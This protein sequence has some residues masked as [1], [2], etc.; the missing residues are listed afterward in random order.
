MTDPS[1]VS[2]A[3]RPYPWPL[4]AWCMGLAGLVLAPLVR[5]GFLLSYDMVTVPRQ[6]LVP[7]ALGLGSALPRAVPLDAVVAVLTQ[8]VPGELVYRVALV[9]IL[10]GG[11]LGAAML[12]PH[13]STTVRV[14]AA[15]AYVWNAYVAERLVIGHWGLL[16]AYAVLP[17]LLRAG[18]AV[19]RGERGSLPTA[20]LLAALASVTPTG[21]VLATGVLAVVVALPGRHRWLAAWAAA[22]CVVLQLPWVVPAVLTPT[23]LTSDPRAVEAFAA[24]PDSPLGLVGSVL[25]LGG[26][27]N[28][29]VVPLS[30]SLWSA[31]I[32]TVA[33]VGLGLGGVGRLR[34]TVGWPAM[35]ALAGLAALG[36]V[37]SLA[38]TFGG[39]LGWAVGHVPGAGLLR[40]GPKF[41]AWYS[42]ALAPA[43]AL[44][45][46]RLAAAVS[47][48]SG[49]LVSAAVVAGVAAVLP[50]A[51]LPDLAWGVGGR[52]SPVQYPPDWEDVRDAL[53]REPAAGALVVLPYQPYRSFDWNDRRTVLDPLPRYAGVEYVVPDTLTVGGRRLAGEDPRAAA[54]AEALRMPEPRARLLRLG[55]GWVAVEHGTPGT[56]STGLLRELDPVIRG[57]DLELYRVRGDPVAWQAVAPRTPVLAA[58]LAALAMAGLSATWL[59]VATLTRKG[60]HSLVQSGQAWLHARAKR[61][62]RIR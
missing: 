32:V 33:W 61:S 14:V 24:H 48:W 8:V 36:I 52:L 17:W 50:L 60:Q 45:A 58:H 42:L 49:G 62:R 2:S 3:G 39:G 22:G 9:G 30:R 46:E 19:R 4:V 16:V 15:S 12:L 25:T 55:V 40:D 59:A 44:G 7:D 18:L 1:S 20:L 26:I 38:G 6:E 11:A 41:L 13:A 57:G 28:S 31:T 53:H 21:G 47:R 51:A 10:A 54:V 35:L 23:P 5:P 43:A 27:W 56:V 34:A 37:V 29:D